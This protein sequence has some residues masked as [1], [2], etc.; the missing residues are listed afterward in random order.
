M[1]GIELVVGYVAAWAWRKARRVAGRADAEVDQA[2][3]TG[4]DR[5]HQ[6]IS[7]KLAGDPAL[8]QLETE[9]GKNLEVESVSAR[10]RERVRL[11][12]EDAV[13][14]DEDF[15]ARLTALVKQL[16]KVEESQGVV[17]G[18]HGLAASGDVSIHAEGGSVASAVHHGNVTLGNPPPPDPRTG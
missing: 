4:M 13:E 18:E 5:L 8:A 12:L 9:A 16:R 15:E 3:D 6:L 11:A 14:A 1:I 10:T 2:L 17:A 7:S